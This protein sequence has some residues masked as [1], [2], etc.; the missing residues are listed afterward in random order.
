MERNEMN[1][2][3]IKNIKIKSSSNT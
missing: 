2:D 1:K 3:K